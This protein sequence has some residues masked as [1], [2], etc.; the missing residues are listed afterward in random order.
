MKKS[1]VL[2]STAIAVFALCVAAVSQ[3]TWKLSKDLLATNNQISF[4]QG[5]NGVWYSRAIPLR[6]D[7]LPTSSYLRI[8]SPA[9]QIQF[10]TL[11]TE[12]HV[13][14]ILP[15]SVEFILFRWWG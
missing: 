15:W 2:L 6:T 5:S 11:L 13:G 12:W 1:I 3:T 8:S 7:R 10:R 4:Q 9:Y 14:K